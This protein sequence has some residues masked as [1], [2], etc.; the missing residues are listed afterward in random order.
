MIFEVLEKIVSFICLISKEILSENAFSQGLCQLQFMCIAVSYKN[1]GW[2]A[3]SINA[4]MDFG[5]EST[6]GLGHIRVPPFAP[7]AWG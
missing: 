7:A 6:F 5:I 3:M 4:E 2:H 1:T